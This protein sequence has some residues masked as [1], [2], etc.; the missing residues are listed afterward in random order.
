MTLEEIRTVLDPKLYIGR[1]P[2]QVERYANL[3]LAKAKEVGT[4]S[5]EDINL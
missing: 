3:C 1:C 5:A 4:L 2:E